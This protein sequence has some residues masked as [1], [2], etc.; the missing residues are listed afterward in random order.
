[1]KQADSVPGP[2]TTLGPANAA[3]DANT[4]AQAANKA[5]R[6]ILHFLLLCPLARDVCVLSIGGNKLKQS[7]E[8]SIDCEW[9]M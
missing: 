6:F 8:E 7:S 2:E 4:A 1:V 5:V 9:N 3:V